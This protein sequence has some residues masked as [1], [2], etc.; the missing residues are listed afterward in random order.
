MVYN[1]CQKLLSDVSWS[2]SEAT[3]I[4]VLIP[5][6]QLHPFRIGDQILNNSYKEKKLKLFISVHKLH[7]EKSI[8][9]SKHVKWIG[10]YLPVGL[11]FSLMQQT[12]CGCSSGARPGVG[13][14]QH[15]HGK[16]KRG[17][18]GEGACSG[19]GSCFPSSAEGAAVTVIV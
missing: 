16:R 8:F 11:I 15:P 3:E 6:K 14:L 10:F 9:K 1:P 7:V 12:E 19:F 5:E 13:A 2:V 18:L 17:K 4:I